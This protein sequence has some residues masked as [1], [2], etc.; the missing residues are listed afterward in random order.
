MA[1][2]QWRNE[3]PKPARLKDAKAIQRAAEDQQRKAE[4]SF[5][6][7]ARKWWEWWAAGK[8]LRHADYVLRRLETDVFPFFG[9][10]F[11]DD[12]TAA[13]IRKLMLAIE[14]RGARDVAKR[15]HETTGQIFRYE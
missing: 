11:I 10:K 12:V 2:T 14:G 15:A 8:S 5:E 9:H 3:D 1:T 4:S 13:D 6:N 7:V